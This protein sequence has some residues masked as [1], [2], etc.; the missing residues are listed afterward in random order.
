MQ[1]KRQEQQRIYYL[2]QFQSVN[3][4]LRLILLCQQC[5][6]I[7]R[8]VFAGR[9]EELT[10]AGGRAWIVVELLSILRHEVV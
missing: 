6:M 5:E 1:K 10:E 7:I 8:E 3:Q 4:N 2:F 9:F